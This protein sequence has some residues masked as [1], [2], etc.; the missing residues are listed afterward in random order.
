M[1]E[2]NQLDELE[3]ENRRLHERIAH[4]ERELASRRVRSS[5]RLVRMLVRTYATK[6]LYASVSR[7]VDQVAERRIERDTIKDVLYATLRRLTRVGIVTILIAMAPLSL[8]LL[9]TY[10]LKKQNDKLD[11][12]NDRIEQQTFLQ[13]AER[14][15]SLVF[16]FDNIL[17]KMD[18]ELRQNPRRELSPQLVGRI[19][20]LTKAL[21]PYRYLEGDTI[22]SRMSSPERGQVLISLLAS[23]L[24]PNTYAQIFLQSDFSYAILQNAN[25]DGAPLRHINLSNAVLQNIS[26]TGADLRNAN[27]QG[28]ELTD[29]HVQITGKSAQ[30]ARFDFANFHATRISGADFSGSSFEYTNFSDACLRKTIFQQ[31]FFNRT[32][33]DAIRA[34]T[35]DFSATTLLNTTFSLAGGQAA[36]IRFAG[37][38]ADS[39]TW[40]QIGRLPI[41]NPATMDPGKRNFRINRDT[42]YPDDK[43]KPIVVEDSVELFGGK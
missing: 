2:R 37:I 40:H 42:F 24:H 12:Q 28:A 35:L 29:V 13:E 1:N 33:F 17:A 21:K 14:R 6:P 39:A 10:Y 19:V 34:D 9:Q 25:L 30:P 11:I 15:S 8:A 23:K 43:S 27:L 32:K 41:R 31:A 36:G 26:L 18:E 4:L 38:Q 20:A 22:T 16:L 3:A 7:L 5:F